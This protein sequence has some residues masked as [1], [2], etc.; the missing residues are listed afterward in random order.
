MFGDPRADIFFGVVVVLRDE[1][2][3]EQWSQQF[4]ELHSRLRDPEVFR[5][6][7]HI[8]RIGDHQ[9]VILVPQAEPVIDALDR[10]DQPF[11]GALGF[12]L[13]AI[14]LGHVDHHGERTDESAVVVVDGDRR[15]Q[16]VDLGAIFL[17]DLVGQVTARAFFEEQRKIGAQRQ[18]PRFF[19]DEFQH[20]SSDHFVT[21]VTQH[22]QPK[23]ADF[24]DFPAGVDRMHH[25][26]GAVVQIAKLVF[27]ACDRPFGLDFGID[28]PRTPTVTLERAVRV[29]RRYARNP[30]IVQLAAPIGHL[31]RDVV[32][33]LP[34]IQECPV[35]LEHIQ[36]EF[37][38]VGLPPRFA[39]PELA[40]P[41]GVV[42]IT[43]GDENRAVLVVGLPITVLGR[44][45][46]VAELLLTLTQRFAQV[47][48]FGGFSLE[49]KVGRSARIRSGVRFGKPLADPARGR[50]S[51]RQDRQR[52]AAEFRRN[53]CHSC[54]E[55]SPSRRPFGA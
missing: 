12:S 37:D 13:R 4:F 40:R 22:L 53:S 18:F 14:A 25:C 33:R 49:T 55:S 42:A 35:L 52:G 20:R 50:I 24:D 9:P 19:G 8:P 6:K 15:Q 30:I 48:F 23:F 29:E 36:I 38:A 16:H 34:S 31:E 32:E 17:D 47:V 27:R 1:A 45:Q 11:P 51:R 28:P 7:F 44:P 26:R 39:V 2:G 10:V 43:L 54:V 46:K 21:L 5:E 3:F 41:V